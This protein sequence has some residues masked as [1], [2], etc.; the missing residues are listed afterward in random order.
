MTAADVN[1]TDKVQTRNVNRMQA[2]AQSELARE[3]FASTLDALEEKLNVPKQMGRARDR[4][5]VRLRRLADEQ[6]GV[7]IGAGVG[8]ALAIGATVWLIVRSN[9]DY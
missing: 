9:L 2:R 6:P 8:A 7:L 3:Q 1:P 4:A 5:K